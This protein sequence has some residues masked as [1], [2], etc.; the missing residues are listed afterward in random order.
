VL[1]ELPGDAGVPA[2]DGEGTVTLELAP[3]GQ[4]PCC[5]NGKVQGQLRGQMTVGQAPDPVRAE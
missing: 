2:D 3:V 4:H 5:G 1:E